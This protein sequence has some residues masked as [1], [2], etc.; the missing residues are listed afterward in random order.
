MPST[1]QSG[2]PH[3][4]PL[5]RPLILVAVHLELPWQLQAK[6]LCHPLGASVAASPWCGMQ[7]DAWACMMLLTLPDVAV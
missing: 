5:E 4:G 1:R 3:Q 7:T 6:M 2:G